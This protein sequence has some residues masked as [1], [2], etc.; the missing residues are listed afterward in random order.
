MRSQDV[1]FM[2]RAID[3]ARRG[4]GRTSPNPLVGA[5]VVDDGDV[6]GE[7][8]HEAAGTAHA[9]A[10]AL[11]DAGDAADGATLYVNLEPCDHHGRTPP[12]SRAIVDAG[13]DRVVVAMRDPNPVSRHGIETLEA[14]GVETT[15]GVLRDEA[16]RLNEVFLTYVREGRP[17]VVSKTAM[18]LDG[19]IAS[20]TGDAKWISNEQSRRFGH[21]LRDRYDAIVVGAGT[22][23]SDDPRLTA[24]L[25]DRETQNP[26]RVVLSG[27]L[28]LPLDATLFDQPGEVIVAT[29]EAARETRGSKLAAL[30]EM[31]VDVVFLPGRDPSALLSALAERSLTSVLVEGG[32]EVNW[33]FYERGLVDKVHVFVAPKIV[34]GR[35]AVPAVG[36]DGFERIADAVEVRD[37]SVQT[38]DGDVLLT[39]Y[40]N[41]VMAADEITE[42]RVA[43]DATGQ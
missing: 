42:E 41:D 11:E 25:D 31:G 20:K 26:V 29:S 5:V 8:Y 37:V 2:E 4:C 14:N 35:G 38:F 40:A 6:V 21:E 23:R 30:R 12:C 10:V 19:K 13:V 34:G 24:R 22:V 1:E 43:A 28:D 18:T 17:F 3:L 9:E 27:D 16:A 39:G 36:G 7:G 32:A 33:S 15:V